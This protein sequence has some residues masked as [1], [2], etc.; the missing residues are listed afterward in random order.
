MLLSFGIRV[1]SSCQSGAL[2]LC[3]NFLPVYLYVANLAFYKC[4]YM[5]LK[6]FLGEFWD[7]TTYQIILES[8]FSG[9]SDLQSVTVVKKIQIKTC[10]GIEDIWSTETIKHR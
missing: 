10:Q 6:D 8:I 7:D 5:F 4:I 2:K 1:C 9:F 3:Y